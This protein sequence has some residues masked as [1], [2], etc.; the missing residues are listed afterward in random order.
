[1]PPPL[2]TTDCDPDKCLYLCEASVVSPTRWAGGDLHL[3]AQRVG[4]R[5]PEGQ[6]GAGAFDSGSEQP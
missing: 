1:M 5:D 6:E 4:L 3:S 2:L